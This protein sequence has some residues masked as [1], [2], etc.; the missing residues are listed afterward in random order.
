ME[1][2]I[3]PDCGNGLENAGVPLA[4]LLYFLRERPL[5]TLIEVCP[6]EFDGQEH[7]EG[8]MDRDMGHVL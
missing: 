6:H 8:V 5:M 3:P 4:K 1:L 7:R 2:E